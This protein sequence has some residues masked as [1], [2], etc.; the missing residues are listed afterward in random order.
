MEEKKVFSLENTPI[1]L[2]KI[3]HIDLSYNFDLLKDLLSTI[4]KH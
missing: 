1:D 3:F 4:I 2:N